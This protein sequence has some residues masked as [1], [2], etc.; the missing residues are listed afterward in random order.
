MDGA[1]VCDPQLPGLPNEGVKFRRLWMMDRAA[2]TE[3]RSVVAEIDLGNTPPD[4]A[5]VSPREPVAW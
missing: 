2:A 3:P 4:I 1:R 5:P